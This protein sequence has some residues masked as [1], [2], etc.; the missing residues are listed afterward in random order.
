MIIDLFDIN[1]GLGIKYYHFAYSIFAS[2]K[3]R[4]F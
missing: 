4:D 3:P 1:F 2:D